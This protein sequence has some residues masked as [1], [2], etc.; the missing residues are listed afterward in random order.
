M[1]MRTVLIFCGLVFPFLVGYVA[2]NFY[3]GGFA[4]AQATNGSPGNV[5]SVILLAVLM[6]V[7]IFSSF[8]FEKAKQSSQEGV[9]ISLRLS[10][11]LTDFQFIAALFVSPLIFNSIYALTNQN[12]ETLG[13]FL[14]AYQNGFF[15][16]TV[17][18]G[19]G[20]GMGARRRTGKAPR[21]RIG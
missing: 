3:P 21:A 4:Q 8:V 2:S 14:L 5:W 11:I 13:D 19:V 16:Q 17:L 9:P 15:W 6:I 12:P 10:S 18:A 20:S 7:G 1:T